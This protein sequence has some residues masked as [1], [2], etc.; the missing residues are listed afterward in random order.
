M[1]KSYAVCSFFGF[2]HRLG[3][4][5]LNWEPK[6][7]SN[8]RRRAPGG[9]ADPT[10]YRAPA[11]K[12]ADSGPCLIF[13]RMGM[14]RPRHAYFSADFRRWNWKTPGQAYSHFTPEN[15][16]AATSP[17]RGREFFRAQSARISAATALSRSARHSQWFKRSPFAAT[18]SCPP[19][20]YTQTR[21]WFLPVPS[22][23]AAVHAIA[24][25]CEPPAQCR[26]PLRPADDPLGG[27]VN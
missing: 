6:P 25:S 18:S 7:D 2:A 24:G 9:A 5:I 16:T 13:M 21:R 15:P 19:Q 27:S 8:P 1:R 22:G 23:R 17:R 11:A 26:P 3:F 4:K 10:L 12:R 20:I 14:S